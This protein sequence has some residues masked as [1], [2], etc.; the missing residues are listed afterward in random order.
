M[1]GLSLPPVGEVVDDY[2]VGNSFAVG[3]GAMARKE[4]ARKEISLSSLMWDDLATQPLF[5]TEGG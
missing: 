3:L 1:Q 5:D 4:V 2:D